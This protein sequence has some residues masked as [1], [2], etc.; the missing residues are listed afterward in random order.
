M[1]SL[2]KERW[3]GSGRIGGFAK[4]FSLRLAGR[5]FLSDPPG[6]VSSRPTHR[7]HHTHNQVGWYFDFDS[8]KDKDKDKHEDKDTDKDNDNSSLPIRVGHY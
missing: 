4:A 3:E 2:G 5:G 1:E 6:L 8:D 7:Y